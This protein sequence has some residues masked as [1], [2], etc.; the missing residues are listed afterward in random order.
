TVSRWRA[1]AANINR[2]STSAD[3]APCSPSSIHARIASPN[4]VPPGSR[5]AI[6]STPRDS[7][8]ARI[9]AR[10]VVLPTPSPPSTVTIAPRTALLP[11]GVQPP[12][13]VAHRAVVLLERRGERVAAV[14]A[15]A[16]DE[17]QRIRG[18]RLD[19]CLERRIA[20]QRDRRRRQTRPRVRVLRRVALEIQ[21]T[22]VPV[23][24]LADAVDHGRVRLQ[25]HSWFDAFLAQY[26]S[27]LALGG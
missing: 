11:G 14:A 21:A 20:R 22:Q 3:K 10:L 19:G 6:A 12:Q 16:R 2:A 5:V 7:R 23:V 9:S 27:Q 1:R 17:V 25:A 26:S 13:V 8:C 15:A 24:R 4:G 18:L